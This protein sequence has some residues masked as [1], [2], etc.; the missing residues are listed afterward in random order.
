M[1]VIYIS[2]D[3]M[4][5]P[6]GASQVLPYLIELS[7]KNIEFYLISFEKPERFKSFEKFVKSQ[8]DNTSITWFP[9][10]YTKNPPVVS[11]VFDLYKIKKL[12]KRLCKNNQIDFIHA[13]SYISALAAVKIKRST[14]VPFVF[15]MRGFWADERIDG[16]IWSFKNPLYKFIYKYFK[17]KEKQL[18]IKSDKIVSLTQAAK[19]YMI[20]NWNVSESKIHVIPCAADYKHFIFSEKTLVEKLKE[21]HCISLSAGKTLM[22]VGSTGTWYLLQ[23]MFDFYSVLEL[24]CR[25][26]ICLCINESN[27]LIESMIQIFERSCCC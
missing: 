26:S 20:D 25:I 27:P 8:I 15:D 19:T 12:C 2:Y 11:T 9:L 1:K 18:L 16:G 5:D 17:E 6:V 13:R 21:K 22:Y 3:G 14:Q 10:R 4:C 7:K 24:I 23:Q